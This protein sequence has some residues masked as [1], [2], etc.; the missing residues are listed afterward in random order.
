VQEG[1]HTVIGREDR[2]QQ[3][4]IGNLEREKS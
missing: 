3:E 1:K 4:K 2:D